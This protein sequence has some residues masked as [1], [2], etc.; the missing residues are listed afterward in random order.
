[1]LV[2]IRPRRTKM[3]CAFSAGTHIYGNTEEDDATTTYSSHIILSAFHD[4]G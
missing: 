2:Y 4:E 3:K 1:M